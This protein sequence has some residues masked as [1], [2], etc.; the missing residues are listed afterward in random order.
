[1]RVPTAAPTRW[2]HEEGLVVREAVDRVLRD[3]PWILGPEVESFED[4]F[5]RYTGLPHAVGV[6]NGTDALVV[7]FT[8][9]DLAPGAG[10]LVAAD[11]GGYAA[12][13]ARIAG[14]VPVVMDLD[15]VGRTVTAATAEHA[16]RPDVEAL[17]VTHL[18]GDAVPLDELDTWRR[19]RGLALVEDC[20][21][22][23]GLRVGD[24]HVGSTGDAA[25]F[26]F[27]PTKNLGA[28]GDG[29]LVAFADAGVAGRARAL[30][31]YGWVSERFRVEL[32][33]ARNTRLDP[34]QAAVLSARLPHLDARNAR[35]RD[36]ANRWRAA[37][38]GRAELWGDGR[39]T[40][41]HHAVV[42]TPARDDL[43]RHLAARD[44]DTAVH[45]PHVVGD[46]PGLRAEGGPTPVAADLARTILTVP[47]FPELTDEEV[48]HVESALLEWRPRHD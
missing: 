42:V 28:V 27:Y 40:V 48:H 45:Y 46:M 32:P 15:P 16:H 30:R 22:A 3:G 7:A 5:A 18:H 12:T 10:V 2:D 38:D 13:A 33:N 4:A 39:T 24:R 1:M 37:L 47:C 17:V 29:G 8:A 19:R 43:A 41:A 25:T 14:L 44:I 35:R 31:Q 6:G 21:Q 23:H 9:L 36:V 26:S 20:A 34:L 11:E